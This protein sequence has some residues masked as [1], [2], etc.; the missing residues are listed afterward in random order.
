MRDDMMTIYEAVDGPAG[1]GQH[2]LAV[3]LVGGHLVVPTYL[4]A[5]CAGH[6]TQRWLCIDI[7]A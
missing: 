5:A 6:H 3:N 7:R 1:G 2:A 4:I